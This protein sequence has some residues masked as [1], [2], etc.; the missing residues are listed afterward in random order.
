MINFTFETCY[1]LARFEVRRIERT[2]IT[3]N[4]ELDLNSKA[5]ATK[6]RVTYF[7]LALFTGVSKY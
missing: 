1:S 3:M 6:F 5:T 2:E 7:D 4:Y